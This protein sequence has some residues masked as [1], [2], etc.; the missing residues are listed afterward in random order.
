MLPP[1]G[2]SSLELSKSSGTARHH[3]RSARTSR[4]RDSVGERDLERDLERAA[5]Y[6]TIW[7]LLLPT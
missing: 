7:T 6:R 3:S 5:R 1:L 4:D 2:P